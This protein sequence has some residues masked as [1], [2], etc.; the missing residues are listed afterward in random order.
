M[1]IPESTTILFSRSLDAYSSVD[2]GNFFLS[3][4]VSISFSFFETVFPCRDCPRTHSIYQA[5]L[6]L[7]E[8]CLSSSGIKGVHHPSWMQSGPQS[9]FL[10]VCNFKL[11]ARLSSSNLFFF[12]VFTC[13]SH[14]MSPGEQFT[15]LKLQF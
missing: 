10:I 4:S 1:F 2:H 7:L 13:T 12:S 6:E 3:L 11:F 5:G 14:V 9:P 15:T 8:I